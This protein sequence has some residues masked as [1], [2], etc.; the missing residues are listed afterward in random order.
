LANQVSAI[1]SAPHTCT[2]KQALDTL[3]YEID[4]LFRYK[5]KL[6]AIEVKLT[7]NPSMRDFARLEKAAELI[8][9]DKR[10]LVSRTTEHSENERSVSTNLTKVCS[11]FR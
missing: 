10:V 2:F 9:A 1:C 7:S 3:K 4:L 8:G 5:G 11:L 6:W